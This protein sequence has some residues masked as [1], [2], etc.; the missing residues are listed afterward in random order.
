MQSLGREASHNK[1]HTDVEA[2]GATARL[3]LPRF[4][5]RPMRV[6]TRLV[7]GGHRTPRGVWAGFAAV[8]LVASAV[9]G[10]HSSAGNPLKLAR[11]TTGAGFMVKNIRLSG[12]EHVGVEDIRRQLNGRMGGDF[13]EFDAHEARKLIGDMAW[14]REAR[15]RKIYPDTLA[16]DIEERS[17][18]AVWQ[19]NGMLKLV[20]AD[21]NVLTSF[22]SKGIDPAFIHLPQVVGPGANVA[23]KDFLTVIGEYPAIASSA[24]AFVRVASRRWDLDM[25]D[26]VRVMLPEKG[27][28]GALDE[29][30]QLQG[31]HDLLARDLQVVDLRLRDR[32]TVRLSPESADERKQLIEQQLKAMKKKGRKT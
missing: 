17:A 6:A 8:V 4:L 32:V 15:V 9:A 25:G 13:I 14:V 7:D 19:T 3:V 12:N 10:W 22:G 31:E 30:Y 24:R 26:G 21:G 11:M 18:L 1:P 23:A 28:S 2:Q 20:A 5:R 16:I 27:V 29:L